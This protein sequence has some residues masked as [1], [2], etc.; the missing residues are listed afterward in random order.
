MITKK[1]K[2]EIFG[3]GRVGWQS[4]FRW[5]WKLKIVTVKFILLFDFDVLLKKN[6]T[7][8]ALWKRWLIVFS[9]NHGMYINQIVLVYLQGEHP[10]FKDS[11]KIET[12]GISRLPI[13]NYRANFVFLLVYTLRR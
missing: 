10:Q 2:R 7:L 5:R 11:K 8:I 6:V 4:G 1:N 3:K 13:C 9:V 12:L